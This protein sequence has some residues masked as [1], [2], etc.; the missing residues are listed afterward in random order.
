MITLSFAAETMEELCEKLSSMNSFFSLD[1]Q[2]AH[3]P[4]NIGNA[5]PVPTPA[6]V[7]VPAAAVPASFPAATVSA[8][9]VSAPVAPV[10]APAAPV[11]VVPTPP[12]V[13]PTAPAPAY[14]LDTLARACG[15]L[16]DAGRLEQVQALMAQYGI[17]AGQ[18]LTSMRPEYYGAFAAALR[19]M[20]VT[21]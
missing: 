8:A 6:P 3:V 2:T 18:G 19:Q 14:D 10:P 7:P 20:G 13:P 16:V 1:A 17:E 4:Q 12:A 5:A 11:P 9:P 21:I 15:Q